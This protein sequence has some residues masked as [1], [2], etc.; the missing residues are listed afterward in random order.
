MINKTYHSPDHDELGSE[1]AAG[2]VGPQEDDVEEDAGYT[3]EDLQSESEGDDS[4]TK[5]KHVHAIQ[6]FS[7]PI[8]HPV[9]HRLTAT[10][11]DLK[12]K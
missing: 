8:H 11:K 1:V 6:T 12:F 9:L 5:T 4:Q 7:P 2:A 3:V 10:I